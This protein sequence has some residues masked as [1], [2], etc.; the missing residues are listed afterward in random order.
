MCGSRRARINH[1]Y[2]RD[3]SEAADL[4]RK[5]E[6]E[7][8]RTA[9]EGEGAGMERR[10][11]KPEDEN[12]AEDRDRERERVRR[13]SG[14]YIATK[15]KLTECQNF[16]VIKFF[17][18]LAVNER[19]GRTGY[20]RGAGEGEESGVA[21]VCTQYA[22]AALFSSGVCMSADITDSPSLFYFAFFFPLAL[23]Q[24]RD[25]S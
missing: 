8:E 19:G 14:R 21:G 4:V 12:R 18:S 7:R 13:N 24:L 23:A 17:A 1:R 16:F 2:A 22:P 9:G 15:T 25:L 10:D 3:R 6:R 5:S 11:E 20:G